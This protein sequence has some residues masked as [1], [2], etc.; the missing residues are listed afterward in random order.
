MSRPARS[1]KLYSS[2]R[3]TFPSVHVSPGD[4]HVETE[5]DD[6]Q[7][8]QDH[9]SQWART[10]QKKRCTSH[11]ATQAQQRVQEATLGHCPLQASSG[12]G[13]IFR[14]VIR[15]EAQYSDT[16]VPSR[17]KQASREPEI[18][19]SFAHMCSAFSET[20]KRSSD[21]DRAAPN[22]FAGV[23]CLAI[24]PTGKAP[25][26]QKHFASCL[27]IVRPQYEVLEIYPRPSFITY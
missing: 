27:T 10:P 2:S 22:L 24:D 23:P 12:V 14:R 16:E 18:A 25:A 6:H 11:R 13:Y 15:N 19:L 3:T 1:A 9:E 21:L 7:R 5:D 26:G 20:R 4:H 17:K 8:G